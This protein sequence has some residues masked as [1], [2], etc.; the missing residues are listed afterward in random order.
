MQRIV[1]RYVKI[2]EN[3]TTETT[4]VSTTS[5]AEC[6][7]TFHDVDL[8]GTYNIFNFVIYFPLALLFGIVGLIGNTLAYIVIGR[9]KPFTS[10][11]VLLRSLALVD[12][13]VLL[14]FILKHT[15]ICI[16]KFL[17]V[18]EAYIEFYE[19]SFPYLWTFRWFTKTMSI[20]L[21]HSVCCSGTLH[22]RTKAATGSVHLY[23]KERKDCSRRGHNY[24]ICVPMSDPDLHQN[25]IFL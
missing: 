3:V 21:Y 8:V 7:Y 14:V 23:N 16:P 18:F 1:P 13:L 15:L 4:M 20:Y 17:D 10:T 25:W 6:L 24:V 5:T 11:S 19:L 12:N 2:I 22:S 9:E